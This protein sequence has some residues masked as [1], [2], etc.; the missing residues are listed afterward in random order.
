MSV[1][2]ASLLS[3]AALTAA[4]C[5]AGSGGNAAGAMPPPRLTISPADGS[6]GVLPGAP[7]VIAAKNGKVREVTVATA[8][9][10]FAAISLPMASGAAPSRSRPARTTP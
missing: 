1:A 4:S 2:F 10:P 3:L 9:G 8:A 5:S 6:Q 7:V